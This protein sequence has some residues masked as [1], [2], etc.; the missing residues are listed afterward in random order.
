MFAAGLNKVQFGTK[1]I[2]FLSQYQ[3]NDFMK[4]SKLIIFLV[5]GYSLTGYA[6]KDSQLDPDNFEKK[7]QDK[8]IQ[9]VDV[10]TPEEFEKGYISGARNFDINSKEYGQKIKSLKKDQPVL[11]YCLSGARSAKAGAQLRKQGY[12]VY[13]LKG[14]LMQ[15]NARKKPL[16]RSGAGPSGMSSPV[17]RKN[18]ESRNLVLVDFYAKWCAPCKVMAP[19]IE[20]LEKKYGE[21]ILVMKIDA[22]AN[23]SLIDSLQVQAIPTLYLYKNGKSVWTQTGLT[24]GSVIEDRIIEN[25]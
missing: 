4:F 7:V 10:R 15:W 13:E 11:V 18:I 24:K 19:E 23:G 2:W 14:G 9:L 1:V 17:F 16:T 20:A 5:L 8:T 21:K 22:D 12:T 25:L 6:Q 3:L